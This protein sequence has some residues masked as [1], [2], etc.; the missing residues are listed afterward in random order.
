MKRGTKLIHNGFETDFSVGGNTGALGVPIY[1][2]STFDQGDLSEHREFDYAR[3]GNP[4]RKAL[5]EIIADLEGGAKGYAFGSGIAAVSSVLGILSG[6]DHIVAAE[7]IYGGSWRIL[8]TFYK[9]WNLEVTPVD[10]TDLGAVKRAIRPN[11]KALFLETPSNPLLKI[12]DLAGCIK[13]AQEAGLLTIVDNT[14]MTPYLQRPIE[15]G[16]DIV[17]H[18]ATKFLGGHSDVIFGLAVT[19]TEELGK[20]V[21]QMQNGFGAVPGPWD[22]W[23]VMRGIKTL[24]VRLEAQEAGARKLAPWLKAHKNVDA[25]FYPGLPDHPG[26]GINEAQSSG[27]G[28]VLS[29]KTKTT[30]QAIRFLG[31][32]KYAA[33]AVSLGGVE[34][35]ASYPVKMSHASIPEAERLRLGITDTLIR[36]SVGLEDPEDLI[37]DF[38]EALK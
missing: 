14:F 29:F 16:A 23:L 3:S 30:E 36:I 4:T 15:L 6:G 22:T 2:T 18:S 37:E 1:Q 32:V 28:A 9:R 21:Y 10:T 24:R 7:D 5:E 34:T 12:T 27:A 13:I 25:V 33:A 20:R 19:R 26:R 35:I 38:D 8:N 17:V 31:T 11:T